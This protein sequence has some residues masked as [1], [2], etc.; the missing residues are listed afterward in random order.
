ME[1]QRKEA[2]KKGRKERGCW[3]AARRFKYIQG[4]AVA[5]G[6]SRKDTIRGETPAHRI[7]T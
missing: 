3:V 6:L 4:A 2:R 7:S 1:G 5:K